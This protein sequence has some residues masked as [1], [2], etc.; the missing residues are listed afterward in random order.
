MSFYQPL[1]WRQ[2]AHEKKKLLAAV[3][4]ISFAVALMLMQLGFKD[5]LYVSA[6][7]LH[8]SMEGELVLTSTL[9]EALLST[10]GIAERRLQQA[11]SDPGVERVAPVRWSLAG[12][13][14]PWTQRRRSILVIGLD[15]EKQP[16]RLPGLQE[17][18]ALLQQPGKLI[19]DSGSRSEYGPVVE[20]FREGRVVT[21][22]LQQKDH[23]VVGLTRLGSSFVADGNVVLST[24][25]YQALF[26]HLDPQCMDAGVI[27]LKPGNDANVVKARLSSIMPPDTQVLTRG[28][29]IQLETDYWARATPIGFVFLLGTAVGFIVGAVTV[30]QILYTDVS[31]HLPEYATLKAMGWSNAALS[32][33]VID[34]AVILSVLGYVPGFGVALLIYHAAVQATGVPMVMTW[35]RALTVLGL[36]LLMSVLSALLAL[37][38]VRQ[39]DPAE[40]F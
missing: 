15:P 29:F 38:K 23:D 5:A 36:S 8:R 39:A 26:P 31:D 9:Y 6:T 35:G 2:L 18:A 4:G 1:G 37:R 13:K 12:W 32:R 7:L 14:N 22:E 16:L 24:R 40:V 25:A 17:Q 10:E 30:Y 11:L 20:A 33:I 28:E 34:Q 27:K 19:F 21:T 3:A